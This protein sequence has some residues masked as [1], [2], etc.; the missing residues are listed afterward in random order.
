MTSPRR[1]PVVPKY[2]ESE[3]TSMVFLGQESIKELYL[4]AKGAY[5][6]SERTNISGR[7][8]LMR[9]PIVSIFSLGREYAPGLEG[10]TMK[11]PLTFLSRSLSI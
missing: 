3:Y 5:T 7:S 4:R 10:F 9:C 6:L 11:S 1:H 2:L 8:V